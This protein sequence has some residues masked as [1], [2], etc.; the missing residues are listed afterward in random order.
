MG[1]IFGVHDN[2]LLKID[3][4]SELGGITMTSLEDKNLDQ[5]D[6][7][8]LKMVTRS[9][10]TDQDFDN[11]YFGKAPILTYGEASTKSTQVNLKDQKIIEAFLINGTWELYKR[12]SKKL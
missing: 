5:T 6:S 1:E 10:N 8:V 9:G 11:G 7:Y 4:V 3:S 2:S 12:G